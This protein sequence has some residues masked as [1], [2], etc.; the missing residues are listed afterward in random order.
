MTSARE[1]ENASTDECDAEGRS[2]TV[3]FAFYAEV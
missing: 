3:L 1:F 2:R